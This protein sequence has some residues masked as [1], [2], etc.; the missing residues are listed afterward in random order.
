MWMYIS[1]FQLDFSNFKGGLFC[2]YPTN[3]YARLPRMEVKF[4]DEIS[5]NLVS[6]ILIVIR[7]IEFEIKTRGIL[8]KLQF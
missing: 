8:E 6:I 1:D 4:S 7:T 5:I 2:F 3:H